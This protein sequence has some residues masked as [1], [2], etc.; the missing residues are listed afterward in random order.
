MASFARA[1]VRATRSDSTVRTEIEF[2]SNVG[3]PLSLGI[4]AL[5]AVLFSF[6]YMDPVIKKTTAA[7]N[8]LRMGLGLVSIYGAY[9]FG[10]GYYKVYDERISRQVCYF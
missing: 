4:A 9:D 6:T 3:P 10:F 5:T 2:A 7:G 8:M 1:L